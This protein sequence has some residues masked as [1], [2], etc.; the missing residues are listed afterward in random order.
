VTAP[1]VR[2][3]GRSVHAARPMVELLRD[4]SAR[5]ICHMWNPPGTTCSENA[6]DVPASEYDRADR[7]WL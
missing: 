3:I 7:R 1:P 5:C 6:M 2:P 4:D